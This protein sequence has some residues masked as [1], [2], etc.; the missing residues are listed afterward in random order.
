MKLEPAGTDQFN[1][2][3]FLHEHGRNVADEL[4]KF[5]A[6]MEHDPIFRERAGDLLRDTTHAED[7]QTG[8]QTF[9]AL[10]DVLLQSL[11]TGN[12]ELQASTNN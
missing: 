11:R 9:N 8:I 7:R 6:N 10:S 3:A 2:L 4:S 1:A 12:T 5:A